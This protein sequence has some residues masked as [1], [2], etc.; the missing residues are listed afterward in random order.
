M[1]LTTSSRDRKP[2]TRDVVSVPTSPSSSLNKCTVCAAMKSSTRTTWVAIARAP[3]LRLL[4]GCTASSAMRY[5]IVTKT[6]ASKRPYSYLR[7]MIW[8]KPTITSR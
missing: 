8:T 4:Y 6:P 5:A 1:L 2:N 7:G 3:W